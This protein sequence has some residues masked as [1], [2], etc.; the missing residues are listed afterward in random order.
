MFD[1]VFARF[2]H[3]WHA[4]TRIHQKILKLLKLNILFF[5]FL[6]ITRQLTRIVTYEEEKTDVNWHAKYKGNKSIIHGFL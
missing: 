2:F 6:K 4:K 5:I 1:K 3:F